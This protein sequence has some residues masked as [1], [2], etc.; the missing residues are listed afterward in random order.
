MRLERLTQDAQRFASGCSYAEQFRGKTIVITGATGLIGS[1]M[2]RC[3]HALNES[4]GWGIQI[5]GVVRDKEKAKA[6]FEGIEIEFIS[7][8]D[9]QSCHL[10]E[11]S[12]DYLVHAAAPTRS[13]YFVSHPVETI[14][15]VVGLTKDAL[16]YC[17]QRQVNSMVYLSSMEVYGAVLDDSVPLTEEMQGH[18]DPMNVRSSY[19]MGKRMAENLCVAYHSEQGVPVKVARL[20]QTF[21]AGVTMDDTRVFAF[22]AKS[23]LRGE[24]VILETDGQ[25]K[26]CYCY[27]T[28]AVNAIL[29]LLL[30]GKSG[31]AYNV[32]TPSTYCS[33]KEMAELVTEKF[34]PQGKVICKG[35]TLKAF[36][37]P[38]RL[39]LSVDKLMALGWQPHYDL[40]AMFERLVGWYSAEERE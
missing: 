13:D 40:P 31:D 4:Y 37:P 7:F 1:V 18:L 22:I 11:G 12:V 14:E 24:D 8:A 20:A 32:A 19:S 25:S 16:T 5:C 3:L 21:G 23:A 30:Q 34:N 28:D 35:A 10:P 36:S 17:R 27:T 29:I 39:R 38:H 6:Q 15:A 26:R 9:F 33:I 2:V